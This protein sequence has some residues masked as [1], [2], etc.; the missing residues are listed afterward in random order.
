MSVADEK[1]KQMFDTHKTKQ[2]WKSYKKEQG[3]KLGS[4][5]W[6]AT[7]PRWQNTRDATKDNNSDWHKAN[8]PGFSQEQAAE[9]QDIVNRTT[10]AAS[11]LYDALIQQ[12][13]AD[14]KDIQTK[15]QEL[16]KQAMCGTE[17]K[18]K[19]TDG[20]CKDITATDNS[21]TTTCAKT[22]NGVNLGLDIACLCTGTTADHCSSGAA[23]FTNGPGTMIADSIKT[24]TDA[25]PK[26]DD[27]RPL[28]EAIQQDI[29]RA[30]AL[31][32]SQ[33]TGALHGLGKTAGSSCTAATDWC[34]DYTTYFSSTKTL[35][36]IPWVSKLQGIANLQRKYE[37][38]LTK[39]LQP[40]LRSSS[41][42]TPPRWN[43]LESGPSGR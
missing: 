28:H 17:E 11:K 42:A 15:I 14:G 40:R 13:K 31:I 36:S 4:V 34:V 26:S 5:D 30:K 12:P 41:Y 39:K 21:K 20:K 33:N 37:Q 10:F 1:W 16:S 3:D 32:T 22:Q 9:I 38:E 24:S 35:Y 18:Y 6:A 23:A 27:S 19:Y 8:K 25:C 29:G 43:I 7:W 2:G